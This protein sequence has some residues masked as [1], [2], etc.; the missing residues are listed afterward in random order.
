MKHALAILALA[1]SA[2]GAP[3]FGGLEAMAE[4]VLDL[5]CVYDG[6]YALSLTPFEPSL[7]GPRLT[8]Q[9]E[10]GF[11]DHCTWHVNEQPGV[12]EC[13]AGSPVTICEGETMRPDGCWY[14]VTYK[15]VG[16]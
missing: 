15:R 6:K 11:E 14:A 12:I 4:D 5:N 2:C 3:N 1:V 13:E 7:C 8:I 16:Y 9:E 10:V